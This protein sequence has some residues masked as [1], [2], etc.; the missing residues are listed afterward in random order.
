MDTTTSHPAVEL[1][2]LGALAD[3]AVAAASAGAAPAEVMPG[4]HQ[5][6]TPQA[7]ADYRAFLDAQLADPTTTSFAVCA[8]DAVV[9]VIRLR[10]IDADTAE[11]GLWL[12]RD[13][14][15]RGIGKAAV[16]AL[17]A[18]AR[19]RGL[20]ALV[21]DTTPENAAALGVLRA[22]GAAVHPEGSKVQAE[23]AVPLGVIEGVVFEYAPDAPVLA[24]P[25]DV[26]H[27][28]GS[29]YGVEVEWVALPVSRLAPEFF[30]LSTRLAGEMLQKLVNYQLKVAVVGDIAEHVARSSALADFVRESN[31][32]RHV[33]FVADLAE[34]AAR[35]P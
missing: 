13:A 25:D 2:P 20:R 23:L 26:L 34:L 21:A 12:S 10:A 14:R 6:W 22:C 16:S 5:D 7:R 18:V 11:T 33:W 35:L 27:V 30:D 24:H 31:R 19:R 8:A 15:G 4:R 1:T 28:I 17:L 32:G 3:Q 29:L 9:G